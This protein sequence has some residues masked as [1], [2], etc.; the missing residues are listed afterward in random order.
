MAKN[1]EL[2][3]YSFRVVSRYVDQ[4]VRLNS[5]SNWPKRSKITPEELSKAGF[6]YKGK[7]HHV[8]CFSCG[9]KLNTYKRPTW[10]TEYDVWMLHALLDSE[11][12]Y[13]SMVKGFAYIDTV[14]ENDKNLRREIIKRTIAEDEKKM[15]NE[16]DVKEMKETPINQH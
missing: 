13:L 5:F 1:T 15:E 16:P 12:I 3:D 6:F 9:R 8:F 10:Q 14:I 4:T 7:N 2:F 11:C